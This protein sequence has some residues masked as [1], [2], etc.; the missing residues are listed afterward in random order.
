MTQKNCLQTADELTSGDR[1]DDYGHPIH[2]FAKTGMIAGA[3]LHEWAKE[4]ARYEFPIPIPP[5]LWGL[6]MVGV[7]I[8]REV[9]KPKAD[10]LVD[11]CGYFRTVEMI[12]EYRQQIRG[13]IGR[14]SSEAFVAAEKPE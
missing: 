7:K 10:N 6:C 4:A 13:G 8:S 12:H 9:N 2:D 5:E 1:N 11:G 3:I 14:G